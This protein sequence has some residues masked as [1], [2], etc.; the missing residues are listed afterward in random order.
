MSMRADNVIHA[1]M[2]QWLLFNGVP[3]RHRSA[4]QV[5]D[6]KHAH[7]GSTITWPFDMSATNA[8]QYSADD[9]GDRVFFMVYHRLEFVVTVM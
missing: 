3:V 4:M 2:L 7:Q 8:L 9:G 6:C 5:S 1:R